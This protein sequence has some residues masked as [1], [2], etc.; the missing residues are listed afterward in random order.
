MFQGCGTGTEEFKVFGR[1]KIISI[2]F[3]EI[4]LKRTPVGGLFV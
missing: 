3:I 2:P 1:N 4:E